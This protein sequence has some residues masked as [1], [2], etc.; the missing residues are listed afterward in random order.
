MKQMFTPEEFAAEVQ[1]LGATKL[2]HVATT[3]KLG[4]HTAEG[5]STLTVEGVEDGAYPVNDTAHAQIANRLGIPLPYYKRMQTEQPALLD[6]NVATWLRNPVERRL[7]RTLEGKARAFLSD[8]Y[9]RIDHLDILQAV[10]EPFSYLTREFGA[11]VE[12]SAL[13][14]TNMYVKVVVPG[15]EADLDSYRTY[16]GEHTGT[17]YG[18]QANVGDIVHAGFIIRNSETG[19]GSFTVEQ[20]VFRL[21]CKNG[22]IRGERMARRHVGARISDSDVFSDRTRRLDDQTI[23]S[24]ARDM[25]EAAVDETKFQAIVAQMGESINTPASVDPVSTVETLAKTND[26]SDTEQAKVL[27]VF[28][29][30]AARDGL[31]LFGLTN[32]VTEASQ[33]VE[34]YERA[35]ELEVLGGKL[36]DT[37]ESEWR[38]LAG[39]VA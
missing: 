8:R 20:M 10:A 29:T 6:A 11:R 1:R 26:L 12:S 14:D 36:L 23:L 3:D 34:D 21:Q 30:N 19:H 28:V 31:G 13:T 5:V 7:V 2:D 35:T 27:S 24:A 39:V 17:Y 38:K 15:I 32:A 18:G 4:F 16:G 9:Q 22:L 33:S 37:S 25:I